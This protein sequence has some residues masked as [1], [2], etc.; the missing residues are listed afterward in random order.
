MSESVNTSNHQSDTSMSSL[1]LYLREEREKKGFTL[2][3]VASA[4][5]INLKVLQNLENDEYEGL[6]AKPFVR[7]FVVSYARFIGLD[8]K[9]VLLK[10][11]PYLDGKMAGREDKPTGLS[12]YAFD[13]R[14]GGEQSRTYLSII[15]AVLV[16]VGGIGL[17]I[18]KPVGR[19]GKH[20]KLE[21]IKAMASVTP[22]PSQS[23]SPNASVALNDAPSSEAGTPLASASTSQL[24]V[25]DQSDL[26]TLESKNKVISIPSPLP[27][28]IGGAPL[29]GSPTPSL[30]PSP[31]PSPSASAVAVNPQDPLNSGVGLDR[32]KVKQRLILKALEDV[33]VRYQSDE[34]PPMKFIL[35][36]G[37]VL[38]IRGEKG[39]L[40]QVSNPKAL[41]AN[42]NFGKDKS[43]VEVAPFSQEA[44][45]SLWVFADAKEKSALQHASPFRSE[46]A[47]PITRSP[48][49]SAAP[50]VFSQ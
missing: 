32:A 3:Q 37:K 28:E 16:V 42:V 41:T 1:G 24:P 26:Q 21:E 7:G 46:K 29:G 6:P 5:R 39:I 36:K 17:M 19:H 27:S 44:S 49:E 40:L 48:E 23:P 30:A 14:E 38:V 50:E 45:G 9:E 18:F 13:R 31:M 22:A 12:G 15:M 2:E 43:F 11:D 34:R 4:T 25:S 35:R 33:W 20:S 8:G 47:L 10:W